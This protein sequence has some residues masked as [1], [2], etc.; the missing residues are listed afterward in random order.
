MALHIVLCP[1][2]NRKEAYFIDRIHIIPVK[3]ITE[4]IAVLNGSIQ[5]DRTPIPDKPANIKACLLYT[6]DAADD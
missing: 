2:E 1:Y 5:A 3:S 4:M 6:S